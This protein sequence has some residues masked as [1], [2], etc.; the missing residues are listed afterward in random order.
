MDGPQPSTSSEGNNQG[1]HFVTSNTQPDLLSEQA[2]PH[3]Q[4]K[5]YY[6][7]I[8]PNAVKTYGKGSTFMD[9]FDGDEHAVM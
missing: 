9:K 1:S 4:L 8:Y 6:M 2:A 5:N 3:S 7:E